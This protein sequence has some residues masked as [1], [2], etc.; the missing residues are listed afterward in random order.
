MPVVLV[1]LSP[2]LLLFRRRRFREA[3]GAWAY[4][5]HAAQLESV[6]TSKRLLGVPATLEGWSGSFS[7]RL[8]HYR[9]GRQRGTRVVVRGMRHWP[10]EL[11]FRPES[12]ATAIEKRL[13]QKEIVLGDPAFDDVIYLRGTPALAL[14]VFDAQT[15]G[16]VASM[17]RGYFRGAGAA[18]VLRLDATI[19]CANQELQVLLPG[20]AFGETATTLAKLIP[21]LLAL[22]RRLD[23]PKDL[24]E[25]IA[26]N[27]VDDPVV[28]VRLANY[29]M[30]LQQQADASKVRNTL[31]T[32][33]RDPS[34]EIRLTAA[35]SLGREGYQ[36][37]LA[38][39][40][41]ASDARAAQAIAALG[42]QLSLEQ[43]RGIL[44]D[45]L[46]KRRHASARACLEALGHIG[47]SG[48][49]TRLSQALDLKPDELAQAAAVALAATRDPAAEQ[50]LVAALARGPSRLIVAAAEA[51]GQLGSIGAV[52][53]LEQAGARHWLDVGVRRAVRQAIALIQSR[54]RGAAPGQLSLA[55]GE[56]GRV[57]LA[58]DEDKRGSLSPVED[59]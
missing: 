30:L 23:R 29:R 35:V 46:F 58:D 11:S 9:E 21:I 16:L 40:R 25:R 15:R 17:A 12:A 7:V 53:P 27:A 5:A 32:G 31:L 10:D 43:A 51:L 44:D 34:E 26:A 56:I 14:A 55:G 38:L 49:I 54:A 37:L 59:R 19:L 57:S 18:A 6:R 1:T 20:Q 39:A 2:L 48:A 24:P 22:A 42:Q 3:E 36:A 45:A 33:L 41:D 8:E 50:P 47:G 28:G 4:A 13:G 52:L